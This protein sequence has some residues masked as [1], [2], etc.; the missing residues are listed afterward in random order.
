[1]T[2][3]TQSRKDDRIVSGVTTRRRFLKTTVGLGAGTVLSVRN[4]AAQAPAAVKTPDQ[5]TVIQLD[6][7][8][9]L[10][11]LAD[12]TNP[13]LI[14]QAHILE[15]L[16]DFTGPDLKV[17]PKL[18]VSWDNPKPTMWRFKLRPNVTWHDGTP[19]TAEDVKYTF[20]KAKEP[21][22]VKN[23]YLARVQ[24]VEILDPLTIQIELDAPYAPILGS[25]VYLYIIQ[26]KAH[27]SGGTAEFGK[28][29]IGTGPYRLVDWQRQ[30]QLVLEANDKHWN[31]VH[32]PKRIVVRPIREAGTRLAELQTGRADIIP[33]VPIELAKSVQGDSNLSLIVQN[34]IRPPYFV[35]NTKRPPFDDRR[36]RQALN[37]A[38]D[39]EGIVKGILQ[40]FGEVRIGPFSRTEPA[41]NPSG[42]EYKLDLDRARALLKEAGKDGGFKFDWWLRKDF[43]VKDEEIMQAIA[44]Q[45]GKI[46]VKVTLTF[47]ESSVWT[48][49]YANGEFDM[50]VNAWGKSVEA[51]SV[52]T[53]IRWLSE[54]S[55]FYSNPQVD[56]AVAKARATFDRNERV[57]VYQVA[58]RLLRE[59]AAGLFTHAQSELYGTNKRY[60][61]KPWPFA[62][63]AGLLTYFVPKA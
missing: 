53:G 23:R 21:T 39:R 20:D 61:W 33:G 10:D 42:P 56:E 25:W 19:F 43:M 22:S 29:P 62:G 14:M 27:E 55:K 52:I 63:N 45:L 32:A 4:A 26:K 28:K 2:E 37:Y 50:S 9:S 8:A 47:V 5:I 16:I 15:P 34:G 13:G 17:T 12:F 40:G 44:N 1:M 46:G 49:R 24:K 35:F 58:D 7:V 18:A 11:P 48:P 60:A 41:F 30:Q 54:N 38:V 59:D 57:K 3:V 36:V 6:E 31:G 51:D